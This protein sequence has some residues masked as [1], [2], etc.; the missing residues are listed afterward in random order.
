MRLLFLN[1][2]GKIGGAERVLL[3]AIAGVKRE[4][5]PATVR[6]LA[7]SDG[8]LLD[9]ARELGAEA[10]L[11]PLPAGSGELGDSQ[12]RGGRMALLLRACTQLPAMWSFVGRLRAAIARFA[13][14]L[15]HS[16]GIKTHLLARFAVPAAVPLV[17]HIHDFYGQRPLASRLLR[18]MRHRTRA[19]IA[20][21]NAVAADVRVVLPGLRVEVVPNAVDLARFS[22]GAGEGAD[23]DRRA[24]LPPATPDSVRVGLVATYARWKGQLTVLDAAA[25]LMRESPGFAVRFYIIGGP[26]YHTAAQFTETELRQEAAARGL[27]GHIGFVPFAAD[28]VPIY[29]ALDVVLHASTLPEPFGLTVAE[30]MACGCA[31]VVSKAGGAAELYTDDVDALGFTPGNAD[32]LAGAVRRLAEDAALRSRLGIAARRRA[33]ARFD[34]SRYGQQLCR[35]YRSVARRFAR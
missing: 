9:S 22:P 5:P 10:E 17:W 13:P 25:R 23:L 12:L 28:P 21:S 34:A 32:Q 33:E 19:A 35:V 14:D 3:T 4:M 26:I 31:V 27:A 16:N 1:P 18:R 29:R 24:G 2:I 8:P 11:L 20:I 7:L 30:A 15:V 6:L